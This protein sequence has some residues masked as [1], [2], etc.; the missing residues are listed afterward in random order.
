MQDCNPALGKL[1]R[2]FKASLSYKDN[3]CITRGRGC[4]SGFEHLALE[5]RHLTDE[6]LS[7]NPKTTHD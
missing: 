6:A 1:W 7:S 2:E 3:E 5:Y 4:S